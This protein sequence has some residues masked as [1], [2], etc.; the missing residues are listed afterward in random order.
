MGM[1]M[2]MAVKGARFAR[3]LVSAVTVIALLLGVGVGVGR[4]A[5]GQMIDL[6]AYTPP[7]NRLSALTL[8]GDYRYFDD[9]TLAD[10]QNVSV[11][12]LTLEGF[13]WAEG[14]EWTYNVSGSARVEIT[15]EA[16]TLT[17]LVD[18]EGTI[19]RYLS[20]RLFAFGGVDTAGLP[21]QP[22]LTVSALVGA[23]WGRFRD[24][25]PMAKAIRAVAALVEKGVLEGMP[26]EA[27]LLKVA[28]A[29]GQR[30]ELG[31]PGVLQA[32]ESALGVPLGVEGVLTLSDVLG[33]ELARFCGWDVSAALGYELLD[34]TGQNDAVLRLRTNAA[35]APDAKT[36][37]LL[38]A[39][40]RT[41]LPWAGEYVF[42]GTL[43]LERVLSPIADLGAMYRLSR[44]RYVD[45]TTETTH[46]LDATLS[47]ALQANLSVIVK[48]QAAW[49]TGFEEPELG[50]SVGF[51]YSLF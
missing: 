13:A 43:S 50:L 40:W 27:T 19:Q 37:A 49:G 35:F 34:P 51:Q 28:E 30:R 38:R 39:R 26:D 15:A 44:V 14:P 25:T 24:V 45:G 12:H 16:I 48:G 21:G 8:S 36:Q 31:L 47:L 9:R 10:T 23:G 29:I 7:E 42:N 1:T 11:G 2:G 32:I 3:P 18:T 46:A 41:P 20:E 22:G 6:C 33:M 17:T 5:W 4:P